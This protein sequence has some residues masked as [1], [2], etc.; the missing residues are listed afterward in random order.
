M[1]NQGSSVKF[2]PSRAVLSAVVS[3]A[4]RV[5][6]GTSLSPRCHIHGMEN[7]ILVH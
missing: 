6:Q 1:Q 3:H 2:L 5:A 4:R 7:N